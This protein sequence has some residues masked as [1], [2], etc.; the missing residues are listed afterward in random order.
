MLILFYQIKICYIR[1][2]LKMLPHIDFYIKILT[3]KLTVIDTRFVEICNV[4]DDNHNNQTTVKIW[5][6]VFY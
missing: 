1:I 2:N 5:G 6:F 3:F 4:C